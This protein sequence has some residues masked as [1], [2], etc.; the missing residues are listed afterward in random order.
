MNYVL[1]A[2]MALFQLNQ[3]A[4]DD[5]RSRVAALVAEGTDEAVTALSELCKTGRDEF[6][7]ASRGIVQIA[8]RAL[9]DGDR[10][11]ARRLANHIWLSSSPHA[12]RQSAWRVLR[13]TDPPPQ[14]P[15]A[16]HQVQLLAPGGRDHD[17]FASWLQNELLD[18]H[19]WIRAVDVRYEPILLRAD[20]ADEVARVTFV[21]SQA[22]RQN[23]LL[24]LLKQTRSTY[25]TAGWSLIEQQ[26]L[27]PVK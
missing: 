13:L 4:G 6:D 23:E 9:V 12:A 25:S 26:P 15:P 14:M 16:G 7:A 20:R 8:E 10:A 11:R 1:L 18:K 24:N 19:D 21:I 22:S 17:R 3:Q 5:L 2:G 27:H